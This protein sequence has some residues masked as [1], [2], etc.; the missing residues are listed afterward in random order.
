MAEN[1]QPRKTRKKWTP[2]NGNPKVLSPAATATYA[3][4]AQGQ[5]HQSAAK[6][7]SRTVIAVPTIPNPKQKAVQTPSS[8]SQGTAE[9]RPSTPPPPA[10]PPVLQDA[11]KVQTKV[12]EDKGVEEGSERVRAEYDVYAEPFIPTALRAVNEQLGHVVVT[13]SKHKIDASYYI[14]T[15]LGNTFV[16]DRVYRSPNHDS[17]EPVVLAE[18]T[19]F[20]YFQI[21]AQADWAAKQLENEKHALYKVELK[22]FE[23]NRGSSL[24]QLYAFSIPG[25]RENSPLVEMGD[26]LQMR[27]LWLDLYG[28]LISVPVQMTDPQFNPPVFLT[29]GGTQYNASVYSVNRAL[30]IVYVKIEGFAPSYPHMG[31]HTMGMRP[32]PSI[33]NV[34]F[35]LKERDMNAQLS[36]LCFVSGELKKACHRLESPNNAHDELSR[37]AADIISAASSSTPQINGTH[38]RSRVRLHAAND[39]IR[40]MLFPTEDD[41]VIQLKLRTYPTRRGMFDAN[42][43]YEQVQAVNSVCQNEYGILPFMI[44]GPPGTGK[45]KTLVELALNLLNTTDIGHILV[46]APS[47]SAADTLAQRLKQHLSP[48]KLFRLNAPSRADNEVPQDLLPYCHRQNDM[49]YLPAFTDLMAY[50]VVVTSCRDAIILAD[51]RVTNTDLYL[52]EYNMQKAFHPETT[53]TPPNLHWGALLIDEAAQATEIDSLPA[54]SVVMPPSTYPNSLPQ[55]RLAMAGDQNQLGPRTASQDPQYSMSLFERLF[56]RSLYASHP[57]S[58]SNLRPSAAPPVMTAKMLPMLHPPFTNL[59]RNYRSHPS[60]LNVPSQLFYA[61]TLIPEAQYPSSDLQGSALW[62]GRKWPVLFIAHTGS[63]EIERDGGGWYNMSE[64]KIACSLAEKLISVDRVQ[65]KDIVIMSPFAAQ[66]KL[67]RRL[68]RGSNYGN[69]RG[70]WDVNI[71]PL[72]AFQGLESRVVIICTTRT[73]QRFVKVDRERG[74][75]IVHQRRKLNVALTRA[76]EG[77]FVIGSPEVL[78]KDE[79]WRSFLAYC[80]RNGLVDKNGALWDGSGLGDGKLG[81]LERALLVKEERETLNYGNGRALGSGNPATG[82]GREDDSWAE[83]LR[84]AMEEYDIDEEN[85]DDGR[86]DS[87]YD[88]DEVDEGENSDD[89]VMQYV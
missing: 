2:L 74:L 64:A 32:P 49:F 21:L 81:V 17:L 27:Q 16:P 3:N 22:P 6:P 88:G 47:D 70:L 73:R 79:H 57:L 63:D 59:I 45:T 31:L 61:D 52:A 34:E 11:R 9:I 29:W 46:C 19:Y 89:G 26:T 38:S 41:G 42:M 4:A 71:G 12:Q 69:G 56:S 87:E 78:E 75:G 14:R 44:S 83:D 53:P 48:K 77:L 82:L 37:R 43:N 50:N 24:E 84:A 86:E 85:E 65:Q 55:P 80:W 58:R 5:A 13:D 30:E 54:L 67:L 8:S 72:E 66:V 33:F 51:V 39:W 28:N 35:P 18:D 23:M 20:Q 60:I 10:P 36:S 7:P 76:K 68:I 40:R 15:F 25:L 62:R 1:V